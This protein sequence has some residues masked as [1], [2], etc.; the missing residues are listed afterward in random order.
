MPMSLTHIAAREA[1]CRI[2]ALNAS[3]A[4]LNQDTDLSKI[5]IRSGT[6][7]ADPETAP[8]DGALVVTLT[9]GAAPGTVDE[10]LFQIQLTTPIEAQITGADPTNGTTVTWARIYDG[11]G[12]VWYD[13]TVTDEAGSGEIKLQTVLL[14]NGAFARL[15]SA[16]FQG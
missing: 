1:A 15:T 2:P 7:P 8:A 11:T 3:L 10:A 16:V 5:E 9:L 14:Y 4:K 12:A 6:M 13:A